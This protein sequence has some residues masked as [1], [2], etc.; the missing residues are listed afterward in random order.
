MPPWFHR[1]L[2]KAVK[3][4]GDLPPTFA[5]SPFIAKIVCWQGA[6]FDGRFV[7]HDKPYH[8]WHGIFAM[9]S[10]ELQTVAGPAEVSNP[11][12]FTVSTRCM[13]WGWDKCP[14][15]V[16]NARLVQQ[17]IV[18]LRWIWLN[19][20]HPRAAWINIRLS[21][22][23][24]SYPRTGTDDASTQT[25]FGR[26]PVDGLVSYWDD[27]GQPRYVDGY[28]PHAGNDILAPLGRRIRAP[29][30][31]LAVAHAGGTRGGNWVTVV[32]AKG[33]VQNDHLSRFGT[34]GYVKQGNIIGY[35]GMTGDAIITHDH[36]EWHPWVP[37]APLHVAPSGFTMVTDA[38]D[39][40]P[41]L[42][43]VCTR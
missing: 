1:Y 36:L 18:G 2:V 5:R 15:R 31:G 30:D 25:P 41:F 12:A 21:G 9:T 10:R 14:H 7:A 8:Q 39:P 27:F 4:S 32:G 35:V 26:C 19:Y 3:V 29:F 40:Y 22:R 33:Y 23:F 34:L 11:K 16:A 17:L 20:G 38:I 43:K 24:N 42:N 13:V 6:D 37:R 28:H